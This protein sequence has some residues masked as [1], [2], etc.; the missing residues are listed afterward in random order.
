MTFAKAHIKEHSGSI[1][2]EK[3]EIWKNYTRTTCWNLNLRRLERCL[4]ID[5]GVRKLIGAD[6]RVH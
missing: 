5:S 2:F 1:P 4:H 3:R 6:S